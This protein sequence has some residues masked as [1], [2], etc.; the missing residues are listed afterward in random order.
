MAYSALDDESA[1][2][3]EM[4]SRVL[5]RLAAQ[6]VGQMPLDEGEQREIVAYMLELI[7]WE[8]TGAFCAPVVRL[9][10]VGG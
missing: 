4:R 7:A 8:A 1:C 6:F 3:S 9:G 10:V 2:D 5:K